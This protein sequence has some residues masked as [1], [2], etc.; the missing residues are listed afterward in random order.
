MASASTARVIN[1]DLAPRSK[2][3]FLEPLSALFV[4]RCFEY[5]KFLLQKGLLKMKNG[6]VIFT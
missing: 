4:L 6:T 2:S 5:K 1:A 3:H